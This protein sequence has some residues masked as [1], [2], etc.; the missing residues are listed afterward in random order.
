MPQL[1][2]IAGRNEE[3]VGEAARRY[4]CEYA[5]HR[6]ARP[7]RRRADRACSTTAARTRCMPSRRSR[8]PRPASTSSARSRSAASADESYEIWK[9]VAATGVKHMCAF[10]YRFVPAVR[11]ARELVEAGRARR[12]A[13]LPRPLPPGLGRRPVARHLAVRPGRR[14]LRRARRPDD[15]RRRPRALPQRRDR[16][17]LRVRAHVPA[18]T[19][20]GRR[21]RGRGPSSRTAR[22]GPSRR[23]AS[24]TA[25]GTRSSGRSTARRARSRSTWSA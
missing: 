12:G 23:R 13:A 4:G 11:F 24:R 3:A 25:G 6:L 2:G 17:R 16:H 18:G 19:Q 22:S 1:V 21:G 10:N 14:R 5:D 15:A 9:R 20:G 7:R 8:P